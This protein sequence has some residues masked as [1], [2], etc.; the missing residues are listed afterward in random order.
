MNG[1]TAGAVLLGLVVVATEFCAPCRATAR[2]LG[3]IGSDLDGVDHLEIDLTDRPDLAQRFGILQ[4][5]TT[6]VLD[7][8]GTVRARIG[9]AARAGEVRSM[10]DD[11]LGRNHVRSA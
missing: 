4:T 10:L 6:L 11:L 9:G 1:F 7:A 8:S 5:P 2:V 3:E